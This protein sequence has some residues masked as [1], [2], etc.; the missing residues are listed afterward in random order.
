MGRQRDAGGQPGR[1]AEP[2][3][4]T[5]GWQI[6]KPDIVFRMPKPFTVPAKGTVPYQ[7]FWLDTKFDHDVWIKAAEV[8]PG[9]PA[10]VHHAFLFYMPP[11]QEEIRGEDPLINSIAGFA[12]G[13]PAS[14]WPDG[15]ARLRARRL[16]AR[17]SDA[18][19][20]QR[21]RAGRSDRGRPGPCR[22]EASSCK[23]VKFEIAVNTDFHIPPGA[24]NHEV[25]AG[26]DFKRD[27]VLHAMMP[28]MHYRGKS[29]RF[30]AKYPDGR[31][32]M[33]L[34][35]PHY[36]FNWQ[37]AYMLKE[38]KRLAQGHRNHVLRP[39]RQ[40]RGQPCRI[41]IPTKEVR[42]GDQTWDEM[43][44]GSMVVSEPENVARGEYPK[45]EHAIGDEYN[46]T[47]RFRP[48]RRREP[49]HRSLPGRFF[50]RLEWKRAADGR[51]R[52]RRLL[53][54]HAAP[55]AGSVRIQVRHQ[56]QRLA[57]RSREPGSDRA[58]RATASSA[59]ARSKR[60]KRARVLVVKSCKPHHHGA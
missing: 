35:V 31:E 29:F 1:P 6:P 54:H 38:P 47:F 53:P 43:M 60:T 13:T 19:H 11:G 2:T 37:N 30:A 51:P 55:Q 4:Y 12:P 45:V 52:R 9:N 16:E 50:Q 44:L 32:E 17:V 41:R 34:D 26:H 24:A 8:R 56:R 5:D 14:L 40:F 22:S 57:E 48:D 21:Q 25:P 18:L 20:A 36:D 42:W 46:V 28:H 58:V 3:K 59:C 39:L 49:S 33:L 15:Y 7:Y 10:V 23:E 27:T